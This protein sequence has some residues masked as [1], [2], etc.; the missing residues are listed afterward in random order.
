MPSTSFTVSGASPT[1]ATA[2]TGLT[3]DTRYAVQNRLNG[4]LLA[5]SKATQPTD[6]D[7]PARIASNDWFTIIASAG[8]SVWVWRGIESNNIAGRIYIDEIGPVS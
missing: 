7:L 5:M 1:T 8:E 3:D 6:S 2:I 4:D